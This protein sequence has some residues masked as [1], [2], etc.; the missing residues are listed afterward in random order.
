MGN[1]S[2]KRLIVNFL[3]LFFSF[4]FSGTAF[5]EDLTI[6]SDTIWGPGT[7]TYDNVLITN[8]ATLTF[9]GAVT[10]NAINL[11][12]DSTSSISAN[13][14]GYSAGQGPGAGSGEQKRGQTLTLDTN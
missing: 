10:L 12:L 7:Y 3:L 14:T 11:T 5:S 1:K 4:A 9:N 13:G 2:I 8:G 6:T